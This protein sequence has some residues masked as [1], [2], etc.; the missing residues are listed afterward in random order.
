M[1][2]VSDFTLTSGLD[3]TSAWETRSPTLTAC[4]SKKKKYYIYSV[5][6]H[7]YNNSRCY[8]RVSIIH[9]D[10]N[11]KAYSCGGITFPSAMLEVL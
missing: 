2:L 1:W 8:N 7:K 10:T 11:M 6:V 5:C 3:E 9:P 4:P